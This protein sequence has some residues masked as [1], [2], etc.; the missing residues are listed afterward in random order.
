MPDAA[1][2]ISA[3]SPR[4]IFMGACKARGCGRLPITNLSFGVKKSVAAGPA[5]GGD[6]RRTG[7]C[8][9]RL[10]LHEHRRGFAALARVSRPDPCAPAAIGQSCCQIDAAFV[11]QWPRYRQQNVRSGTAKR[12][13]CD[14][15]KPIFQVIPLTVHRKPKSNKRER[16]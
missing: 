5:A 12:A 1:P 14:R 9:L 16:E 15:K 4:M 13:I 11:R 3:F 7:N 8:T 2:V 10:S 6:P